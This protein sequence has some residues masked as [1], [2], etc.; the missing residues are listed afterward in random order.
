MSP[1][2]IQDQ[3][4]CERLKEVEKQLQE[5]NQERASAFG[6]IAS[7]ENQIRE[8]Q[9]DIEDLEKCVAEIGKE[10]RSF[11]QNINRFWLSLALL[12]VLVS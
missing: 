7:K 3:Q 2:E 10:P 11:G 12:L 1:F 5:L 9:E 4:D 6:D 8:L